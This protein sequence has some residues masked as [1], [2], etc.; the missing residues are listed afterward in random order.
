MDASNLLKPLLARG[1]LRCIGA[2][3]LKEYKLYIEKDKVGEQDLVLSP[4]VCLSVSPSVCV[5]PCLSSCLSFV[6]LHISLSSSL[7]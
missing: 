5:S 1:E 2:T 7:R 4:S 3:T 6:F